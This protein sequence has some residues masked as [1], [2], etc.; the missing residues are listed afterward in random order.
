MR[1]AM[2]KTSED[3]FLHKV[4]TYFRA[5][6]RGSV[7]KT[8]VSADFETLRQEFE[9]ELGAAADSVFDSNLW[10]F[11]VQ[12]RLSKVTLIDDEVTLLEHTEPV[13]LI[14]TI[15]A[16]TAPVAEKMAKEEQA[17]VPNSEAQNQS[18]RQ[19]EACPEPRT[20]WLEVKPSDFKASIDGIMRQ[21]Q[22]IIILSDPQ[23]LE[24]GRFMLKKISE[25]SISIVSIAIGNFIREFLFSFLNNKEMLDLVKYDSVEEAAEYS[26]I[27]QFFSTF[28]C[29]LYKPV[30]GTVWTIESNEAIKSF[31]LGDLKNR[32]PG[33]SLA[34][35]ARVSEIERQMLLKLPP[36]VRES[37]TCR[38]RLISPEYILLVIWGL[39]ILVALLR[40]L[41][42]LSK[43]KQ[44]EKSCL[45]KIKRCLQEIDSFLKKQCSQVLF[46]VYFYNLVSFLS[47][48]K[49]TKSLLFGI[50]EFT[51]MTVRCF[52]ICYPIHM[53]VDGLAEYKDLHLIEKL[54]PAKKDTKDLR[55]S[56]EREQADQN[57]IKSN[58]EVRSIDDENN[59]K[60]TK[61]LIGIHTKSKT[62]KQNIKENTEKQIDFDKKSIRNSKNMRQDSKKC[63]SKSQLQTADSQFDQKLISKL[64][65]KNQK[66]YI[67]K[68]YFKSKNLQV[69]KRV[70]L[71]KS[72]KK[73]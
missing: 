52:C 4:L 22:K 5:M 13:P 45:K 60:N 31:V 62:E 8:I 24:G 36:T 40:L 21:P 27:D 44:S 42:G 6:Q 39:I 46:F 48:L 59:E 19:S 2:A 14:E 47:F 53:L 34:N 69:K 43:K 70:L 35:E 20:V 16:G 28:D 67:L 32:T 38:F 17:S 57:G 7:P 11:Y 41:F 25:I 63:S 26:R 64:F 50:M 58:A 72:N 73:I 61:N 18:G 23:C 71:G 15:S 49:L 33:Q 1:V 10:I 56:E 51:V 37:V 65:S 30:F 68:T 55:R 3:Q 12:Q 9:D 54:K 29:K 66:K